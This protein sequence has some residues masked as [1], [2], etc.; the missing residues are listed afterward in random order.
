MEGSAP[1]ASGA[2]ICDCRHAMQ[3]AAMPRCLARAAGIAALVAAA[4]P[5]FGAQ[6]PMSAE[7]F[8]DY[9]TGKTLYFYSGGEAYGVEEYREGRRVTWSF[10]D[11]RC[12]DGVWYPQGDQICFVYEDNPLPQCWTF[13]RESG[14][15]RAVFQGGESD[16]ELYE[17]G[18]SDA[19]MTCLGPEVGV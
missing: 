2:A 8:A 6:S 13:F 15:L 5:A 11:G 14:G 7:E 18:E 4:F 16:T 17:A 9:T 12:K 3:G 10:L 19:P 1:L